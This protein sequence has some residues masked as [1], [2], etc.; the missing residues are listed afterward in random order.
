LGLL[1][2]LSKA[3]GAPAFFGV[4][5]AGRLVLLLGLMLVSDFFL[6]PSPE[7]MDRGDPLP[8][9]PTH[10]SQAGRRGW[11]GRQSQEQ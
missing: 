4:P 2:T 11:A 9:L 3:L 7:K 1:N 5:T 10:Q 6:V 8:P